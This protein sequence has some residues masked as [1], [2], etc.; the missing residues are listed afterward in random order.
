MAAALLT[1][2]SP[3]D[4]DCKKELATLRRGVYGNMC[5]IYMKQKK[6]DRVLKFCEEIVMDKDGKP[7]VIPENVKALYR[8]SFASLHLGDTDKARAWIDKVLSL[9]PNNADVEDAQPRSK[10]CW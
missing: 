9:E 5:L 3:I 7:E 4:E 8:L 1:S 6:F 10:N 2:R